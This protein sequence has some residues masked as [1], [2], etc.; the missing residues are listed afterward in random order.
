MG[1][2]LKMIPVQGMPTQSLQEGLEVPR[3]GRGG[4]SI[5]N[6]PA[7]LRWELGLACLAVVLAFATAGCSSGPCSLALPQD[8]EKSC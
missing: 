5:N 3:T 2:G 6:R 1:K 8:K 7:G 4:G